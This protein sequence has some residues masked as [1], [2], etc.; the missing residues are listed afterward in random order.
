MSFKL[1][2]TQTLALLN[3]IRNNGTDNYKERVPV[4][5]Q[6]NIKE[7]GVALAQKKELYNEFVDCLITRIG[8]TI[9]GSQDY[10]NPLKKFKKGQLALG[11]TIQDIFVDI[12]TSEGVFDPTGSNPLSRKKDDVIAYYM[13]LERRDEYKKS[14]SKQQLLNA[15][16]SVNKI[17]DFISAQMNSLYSGA[18]YDE[19]LCT[20]ELL[21]QFK[22]FVQEYAVPD[23]LSTINTSNLTGFIKTVRKAYKEL[24]FM[25]RRHNY[26]GVM[27]KSDISDMTFFVRSDI[28]AEVDVEVLASAFNMNKTDFIGKVIEVENFGQFDNMALNGDHPML[29]TKPVI[30]MLVDDEVVQIYDQLVEMASIINPHG[31]FENYF[32]HIWQLLSCRKFANAV[33]FTTSPDVTIEIMSGTTSKIGYAEYEYTWTDKDGVTQNAKVRFDANKDGTGVTAKLANIYKAGNA[34]KLYTANGTLLSSATISTAVAPAGTSVSST[35]SLSSGVLTIPSG[36]TFD[37]V[38]EYIVV[39]LA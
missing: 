8:L 37:A 13:T 19:Y 5:T 38:P 16:T 15:F 24:K 6:K 23:L 21:G 10:T 33:L 12:A 29:S 36:H 30:A 2:P 1:L 34:L 7:Y 31:L 14:I 35:V 18:E 25:S 11:D 9:I 28:M 20:I 3:A 17:G 4:A 26:A 22:P 39:T 32:Y 27:R